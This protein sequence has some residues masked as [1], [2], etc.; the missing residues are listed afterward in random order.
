MTT[1]ITLHAA[2]QGASIARAVA[3]RLPGPSVMLPFAALHGEW[4][5]EP[6]GGERDAPVASQQLKLLTAGY[7]KAGYHV[8][9]HGE[10]LHA[11]G[12]GDDLLRLIRMV[13]SVRA[14]SV[15]VGANAADV[16]LA[17]P[18]GGTAESVAAAVAAALAERPAPDG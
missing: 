1:V 5:A 7:V 18:A 2:E 6:L 11:T 12:A 3:A 14:L 10:A 17:L 9:V 13:P 16:D 8:V 4:I 15:G